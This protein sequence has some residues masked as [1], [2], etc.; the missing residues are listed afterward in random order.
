MK[1]SITHSAT[2]DR[3]SLSQIKE[4]GSGKAFKPDISKK[5]LSVKIEALKII[6]IKQFFDRNAEFT[7]N[8]L[9][10]WFNSTILPFRFNIK[11]IFGININPDKD[12]AI[13]VAQRI[14]KKLG[15]KLEFKCWR[16]DRSSKQRVYSGCN[17]EPDERNRVFSYWLA[18]DSKMYSNDPVHTL[19]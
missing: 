4:Q 14:L 9:D 19:L 18:R 5:Q 3:Q 15:L 10:E 12:S 2:P 17:I 6:N 7:K 8:S 1:G 16:G 11:D 13:A